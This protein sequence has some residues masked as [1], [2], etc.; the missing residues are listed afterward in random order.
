MFQ[1]LKP[2]LS[3][4]V[5]SVC[6]VALTATTLSIAQA[7]TIR[8]FS[9]GQSQR[10]DLMRKMFDE[11]EKANPGVKI[12]IETGGQTAELQRE[13]LGKVLNAKDSA[14]DVF[15]ID[16]TNPR[17]YQSK[18]WV[19]PLNQY[20]GKPGAVLADH[21]PVYR[22]TNVIDGEI[23]AMPAFADAMFVY[24]RKDL[25]LKYNLRE[26]RTWEQVAA[27]VKKIK[28]GEKTN[29][30]LQGLSIQGAPIEGTVCTFLLPVWS[31]GG[32]VADANG[33]FKL[34]NAVA[35]A[36]VEQWLKLVDDGVISSKVS[37]IK[38]IDTV[39]DFKAGNVIFAIN[40]GFAWDRFQNDADSKVKGLVD[41]MPMARSSENSKSAT[42]IGGWQW[43]VSAFS[44]NKA[45]AAKLTQFMSTPN[46][47]KFLAVE[48]SLLPVF[49][50]TYTE[51]S[52]LAKVPW[53]S[54]AGV[55]ATFARNRPVSSRYGDVS[56][57]IRN[58]TSAMLARKVTPQQG[59][60][61]LSAKLKPMLQ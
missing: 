51:P 55:I 42:C 28:A 50:S 36:G 9:G 53:A 46:V 47:A 59:V 11:F 52:Y 2:A 32:D 17:L 30:N 45:I 20:L 1:L 48:G 13:Y 27:A 16:I 54:G 5:K 60:A 12:Q 44:K 43:A 19:E 41:V 26:P 39:N 31:K 7:Q 21:L 8:V 22:T 23:Y 4:I 15:M 56:D 49:A 18:G 57:A 25:L 24:F 3:T 10:P 34:D 37:E 29:P 33:K 6:C 61:D 38:T 14:L 40:W 35:Q 58:A